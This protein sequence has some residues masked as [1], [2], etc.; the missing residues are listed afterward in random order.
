MNGE[1]A[2]SLIA[3]LERAEV[4]IYL[5][6]RKRRGFNL[7]MVNL[8]EH[9]FS[10]KPPANAYGIHPFHREG[11][12]AAPNLEYFAH[13]DWVIQRALDKGLAVL[14]CPSYLG[15]AG[16]EEGWFKEIVRNGPEKMRGYGRFVG[17]RYKAF[18]NIVWLEGGDYNPP[19]EHIELVNAVAEGIKAGG[20]RQLQAAH[21]NPEVSGAEIKVSGWLDLDTTYTYDPVYLKSRADYQR[22]DGRPHFL[23]ESTYEAE[24]QSTPWSLRGQAYH[25]V[26]TG[27]AGHIFGS[28]DI[29]RFTSGWN[30]ALGS[31]GSVSMTHVRALF[32]SVRWSALEPDQ[33]N[34]V[35]V[36][37]MGKAGDRDY[38]VLSS[39]S[40]GT[41]VLAYVPAVR[42]IGLNLSKMRQ[43]LRG[44]WYD[45]S[46][47]I[48]ADAALPAGAGELVKMTP[49]GKNA[50]GDEDWVLL[51]EHTP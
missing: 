35:L 7:L 11:D 14:L 39:D 43:P 44:R 12:F 31:A 38:A 22:S 50:A 24:R 42:E 41:L 51:I 19:A 49:P 45:P 34:Q 4:E 47:G 15:F 8:L 36:R 30:A 25:A 2:W 40:Q 1:A 16:G 32:E 46:N 29:W 18:P 6:D 5:E 37:G 3:Q 33:Q 26:L 13:A 28:R 21:W 23:L 10:D 9:H 20:A 27:A 48:F 17:D